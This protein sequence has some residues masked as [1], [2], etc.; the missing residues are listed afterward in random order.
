M[1]SIINFFS[2][3]MIAFIGADRF[4]LLTNSFD[5]FVLTPFIGFSCLFIFSSLC[6]RPDK[7]NF[8]WIFFDD[9]AIKV[10]SIYLIT[11]IISIF[12]SIDIY[13]SLKRFLLLFYIIFSFL[14]FFSFYGKKSIIHIILKGSIFGSFIIISFNILLLYLWLFSLELFPSFINMETDGIA[15]FVPRL[16]GYSMDVNRGAV[17]LL[18]FTY[19]LF[20][21]MNRSAL[22]TILIFFGILFIFLSFSRT[23]YLMLLSIF[24]YKIIFSDSKQRMILTKYFLSSIAFL[25]CLLFYFNSLD[26]IN[27]NL[28]VKERLDIFTVTRFTSSGIHLKLIIDGIV[29][30][31]ND[32]KIL[33]LGTGV[34]TSYKLIEGYYWSGSKYGNYHSMY[35]TS[36]V[37]SGIFNSLSLFLFSFILPIYKSY[38]NIFLDFLVCIF[39][40]NIFYQLNMEPLFWFVVLLF[41]KINHSIL[42][43]E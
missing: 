25:I 5:Y 27:I 39:F 40:F 11:A 28:L 3:S 22:K 30:A 24:I 29:I 43:H 32:F 7:F 8:N 10:F 31:F 4:H 36:L 9:I 23:V 37:E 17:V 19:Y 38:K 12:F 20:H 13:L 35:I 15:Y 42:N 33:L 21:Y 41:Y 2:I 34:G 18:F 14:L 6:L 1:I 26:L 16:G